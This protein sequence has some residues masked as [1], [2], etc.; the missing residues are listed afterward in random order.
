MRLRTLCLAAV[1]AGSIGCGDDAIESKKEFLDFLTSQ[2]VGG[3]TTLLRYEED[4]KVEGSGTI[5]NL[6]PGNITTVWT[7]IFNDASKCSTPSC[8]VDD[9]FPMAPNNP[10]IIWVDNGV[11]A[12][13]GTL[14]FDFSILEGTKMAV[15]S[16]LT[17]D[18]GVGLTSVT[19]SEIHMFVVD[20]GPPQPGRE[21]GQRTDYHVGVLPNGQNCN[22]GP[23]GNWCPFVQY[24]P[25]LAPGATGDG[26]HGG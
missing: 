19:T 18:F 20:H 4:K 15:G 25:H 16:T 12:A 11:A 3:M 22:L 14:S 8:G 6:T 9:V 2:P 23:M 1:M 7:V 5:V 21:A 26:G 17:P 24:S 13:D 10:E